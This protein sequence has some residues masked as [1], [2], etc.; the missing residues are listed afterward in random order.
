MLSDS[1]VR[2]SSRRRSLRRR[3]S[4]RT[5]FGQPPQGQP[6]EAQAFGG[7]S[8]HRPTREDAGVDPKNGDAQG[9]DEG[10]AVGRDDAAVVLPQLMLQLVQ[11]M[12]EL[13]QEHA[14]LRQQEIAEQT[15]SQALEQGMSQAG[16]RYS[17]LEQENE[18]L[19]QK[20][21]DS[22]AVQGQF[23]ASLDRLMGRTE[24]N[25]QTIGK[26]Q[27]IGLSTM[28]EM[29]ETCEKIERMAFPVATS[30]PLRK[31]DALKDL[32]G[33]DDSGRWSHEATAGSSYEETS[34]EGVSA[35]RTVEGSK[36]AKVVRFVDNSTDT[37]DSH[38][39]PS[40]PRPEEPKQAEQAAPKPA[41]VKVN[42]PVPGVPHFS[43]KDDQSLTTFFRKVEDAATIGN[44]DN[45]YQRAQLSF[46]LE[47]KAL[48][49][50]EGLPREKVRTLDGLMTALSDRYLGPNAQKDA[51][52]GLR[53]MKRRPQ[54]TPEDYALHVQ[55]LARVAYPG[56]LLY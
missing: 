15:R 16:Q 30:T 38:G 55:K 1:Q 31:E 43:G 53:M 27:E 42:Q 17:D 28:Q 3:S 51:R 34:Q 19:R 56:Q 2:R 21:A 8:V 32:S 25:T 12:K 5:V 7:Q 20:I 13:R 45:A 10:T 9:H 29:K 22:E 18:A 35:P 39:A 44:W 24:N 23:Q 49:Y 37:S 11:E 54:E 47:G 4:R 26:V 6:A 36:P 52:D 46:L 50:V 48:E 33:N 40:A 14:G 41:K